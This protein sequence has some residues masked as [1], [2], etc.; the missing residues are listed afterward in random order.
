MLHTKTFYINADKQYITN[1]DGYNLR[2][3]PSFYWNDTVLCKFVITDDNGAP[4]DL[5]G[6]DEFYFGIGY[7]F[8]YLDTPLVDSD[9]TQFNIVGDW[10]DVDTIQGKIC[11]RVNCSPAAFASFLGSIKKRTAYFDL[12]ALKSGQTPVLLVQS[13]IDAKNPIARV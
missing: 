4:V 12:W 2:I 8:I 1:I 3:L 6:Y 7:S 13:K 9:N 5:S 10:D 11:C